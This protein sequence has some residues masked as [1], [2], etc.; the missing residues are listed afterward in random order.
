MNIT[1]II[2]KKRNGFE[3]TADEINYAVTEF[4]KGTVADYQMSALLMTFYFNNLTENEIFALT[5]VM[6]NSGKILDLSDIAGVKVDKHSSGGVGDKISLIV[7][8]IAAAAGVK[9]AKMSGRGLGFTGGTID[10]LEAISGFKTDLSEEAFKNQVKDIGICIIGQTEDIAKADKLI[11]A[12]RDVTGTVDIPGLI[13]SSIMSKKL[14]MGSDC[15]V[16]DVKYGKGALMKTYD[17][18]KDLGNMMKKIGEKAGKTVEIVLS[19]ME[20]PL[21]N[22]VGNANEIEE[23]IETLKGKGPVD[24]TE[25]AVSIAGKMIYLGKQ[26]VS[27]KAGEETAREIIA[28]GRGLKKFREF[29]EAQG[30]NSDIADDYS[31]LPKPQFT[32]IIKGEELLTGDKN[33]IT[34]LDAEAVGKASLVC[35]AGR[36]SKKDKPDLSAGITLYKKVGDTVESKDIVATIY[37]SDETKIKEGK[38]KL[39]EAYAFD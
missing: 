33:K 8:P 17:D 16:L 2:I 4:V 24:L 22:A 30:G 7:G 5:E 1:D 29:V 32:Y 27:E 20:Q 35:G 37:G 12:L 19:A 38:D 3:L 18:A 14:A 26:A 10:K 28:D 31:L 23:A 21:G 39:K 36:H 13:A 15:M 11:Y 34:G 9:V 6:K 25:L